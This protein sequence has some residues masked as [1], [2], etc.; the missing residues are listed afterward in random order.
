MIDEQKFNELLE[1]SR[2]AVDWEKARLQQHITDGE[3]HAIVHF[4]KRYERGSRIQTKQ[5]VVGS[6][7]VSDL[8]NGQGRTITVGQWIKEGW[9]LIRD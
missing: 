9:R 6:L 7:L 1:Q 2:V 4:Q 5:S 3:T 8:N